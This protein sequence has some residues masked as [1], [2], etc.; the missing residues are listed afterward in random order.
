MTAVMDWLVGFC[1]KN[2]IST[3]CIQSVETQ[4]MAAFCQKYGLRP[5]PSASMLCDQG[6]VIG[7]Y[8]FDV[9]NTTR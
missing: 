2:K 7:D 4:E 1:K 5:N 6:V 3:I 9:D 8:L